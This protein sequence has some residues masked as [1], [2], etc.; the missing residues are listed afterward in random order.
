MR[1]QGHYATDSEVIAIIRRLDVDADQKITYDEFADG[2]R[3]PVPTSTM[4]AS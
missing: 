1:L 2:F 3:A 4:T